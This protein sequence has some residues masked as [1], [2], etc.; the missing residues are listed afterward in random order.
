MLL[1]AHKSM[2]GDDLERAP[3]AHM[4]AWQLQAGRQAGGL[5]SHGVPHPSTQPASQPATHHEVD[6][7]GPNP[8]PGAA[9]RQLAVGAV[10]VHLQSGG[11]A[12]EM[13]A[14]TANLGGVFWQ[15][16]PE[17]LG[18]GQP[19]SQPPPPASAS[20]PPCQQPPTHL[21]AQNAAVEVEGALQA[22]AQQRDVVHAMEQDA[23]C[24]DRGSSR[25]RGRGKAGRAVKRDKR[26]GQ[27]P[28][29]LAAWLPGGDWSSCC[30]SLSFHASCQG[31]AS[32][33]C[34][35]NGQ[36]LWQPR[37]CRLPPAARLRPPPAAGVH[38]RGW[39]HPCWRSERAA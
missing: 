38:G 35:A 11:Q 15:D 19:A 27:L 39:P 5:T 10:W 23:A 14:R 16:P 2:G 29:W 22:L 6:H 8:Q 30:R 12:A 26:A 24:S 9:V 21:Q 32:G 37:N 3:Q 31:P 33:G 17:C 34:K 18:S 4:P 20:L 28:A 1:S 25:G 13:V 7:L 36:E